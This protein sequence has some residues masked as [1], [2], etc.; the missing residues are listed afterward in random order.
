MGVCVLA[1]AHDA[2]HAQDSAWEVVT[3]P[4]GRP[5][6]RLAASG[7]LQGI[8]ITCQHATPVLA[9]SLVD[10]DTLLR[11]RLTISSE[12]RRIALDIVRD[13]R[14]AVWISLIGDSRLLDLLADAPTAR[15]Q[16]DDGPV[17]D[18]SLAGAATVLEQALVGCYA[19][20]AAAF[21]AAR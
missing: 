7:R 2:A 11:G 17:Q 4:G 9:I 1:A 15:V 5:V 21:A 12:G 20:P 14:S 18:I 16:V 3:R 19:K 8:A 13:G 10:A 6:A